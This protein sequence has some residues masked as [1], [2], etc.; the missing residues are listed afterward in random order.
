MDAYQ[1]PQTSTEAILMQ[2]NQAL[3]YDHQTRSQNEQTLCNA[4]LS[5]K[6][7]REK[8]QIIIQQMQRQMK[9]MQLKLTNKNMPPEKNQLKEQSK[10]DEYFTNEEEL[11]RET[12]WIREKHSRKRKVNSSKYIFAK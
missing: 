10:R 9:E 11:S 3:F 2:Q 1:H 5:A 4:W 8:L 7:E 12:E 6:Q